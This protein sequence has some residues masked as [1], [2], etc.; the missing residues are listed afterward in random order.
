M[1]NAHQDFWTL[2]FFQRTKILDV[3][4]IT[5]FNLKQK[6]VVYKLLRFKNPVGNFPVMFK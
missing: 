2:I 1:Q 6:M 4:I 3:Q 5:Y